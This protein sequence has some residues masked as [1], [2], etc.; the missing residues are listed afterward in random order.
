MMKII[1]ADDE[2]LARNRLQA[3]IEELGMGEIVAEAR[4]GKE[5]LSAVHAYQPEIILL[6]IR[7]PGMDGMQTAEA[8]ASLHPQPAVIFTTAYSD[9]AVEAFE[10]H[11]VDYLMK[12]IRKERLEQALKRAYTFIQN[13]SPNPPEPTPAA[14]T[15]ISYY[16]HG[17]RRVV[18]VNQIYYFLSEQKYVTLRWAK[19]EI[20]INEA[21]R[22]LEKEFAGQFLRIHRS[23]LV[24]M[25]QLASFF[26]EK[27][28]RSYL[29]LKDVEEPLEVS[30]RHLQTVKSI[31]KDM[32][33]PYQ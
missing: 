5:V 20:L 24:A 22:D 10:R 28:G 1:I 18:P 21:L 12:P 13:Q 23:T 31:L 2:P 16:L 6:D 11:A 25:V 7:M 3:L 8:L 9:H 33:L 15:H 30:R 26:K 17:E 19:G 32:R 4:N 14:R 27:N 29:R